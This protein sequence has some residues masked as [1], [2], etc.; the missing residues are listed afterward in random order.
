[1][2]ILFHSQELQSRSHKYPHCTPMR[3]RFILLYVYVFWEKSNT[4]SS[5]E[6]FKATLTL[7]SQNWL[8]IF[9]Y[10]KMYQAIFL[11]FPSPLNL[12]SSPL[13]P[14]TS[15]PFV[16]RLPPI[17]LSDFLFVL[18][19]GRKCL[20]LSCMPQPRSGQIIFN[21]GLNRKSIPAIYPKEIILS[22]SKTENIYFV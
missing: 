4:V 13:K 16:W 12:F 19:S 3:K 9:F 17:S 8:Y 18:A 22:P 5:Q 21:R 1:M 6:A 20:Q 7:R 10:F 14:V 11:H 15:T 2:N